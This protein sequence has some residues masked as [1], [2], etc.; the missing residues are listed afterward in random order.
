MK[1]NGLSVSSGLRGAGLGA[2][3]EVSMRGFRSDGIVFIQKSS[4]TGTT[5]TVFSIR[6]VL[7][8]V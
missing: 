3:F 7:K 2:S 4:D 8:L 1:K 6:E 5:G